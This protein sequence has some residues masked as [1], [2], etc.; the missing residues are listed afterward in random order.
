[1]RVSAV[2]N[3]L[4]YVFVV[5]YGWRMGLWD[6]G[7]VVGNGKKKKERKGKGKGSRGKDLGEWLWLCAL[8]H[9]N[10]GA[11]NPLLVATTVA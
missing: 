2:V 4:F 7:T 6:G 11:V 3:D 8:F 9:Q 5:W 10:V 1:M